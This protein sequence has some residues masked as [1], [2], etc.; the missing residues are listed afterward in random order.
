M[1]KTK[2][3]HKKCK[4]TWKQ[5]GLEKQFWK[6]WKQLGLPDKRSPS[7]NICLEAKNELTF[8]PF[9]ISEVFKKFFSNLGLLQKLPAAAKNF[10]NKSLEDY[11][12]LCLT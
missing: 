3:R 11:Y 1:A 8:G 4:T 9:T 7:T 12:N 5:L 6:T 10:G 2:R